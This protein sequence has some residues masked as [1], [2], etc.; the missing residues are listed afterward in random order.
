MEYIHRTTDDMEIYYVTNKDGKIEKYVE[1]LA[2]KYYSAD[3]LRELLEENG[4]TVINEY[5]YY[6]KCSIEE[7]G[8]IIFVC[9][10]N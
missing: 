8:E 7:G 5:G 1:H 9:K 10:K 2:M 6:D 3:Q 4:F